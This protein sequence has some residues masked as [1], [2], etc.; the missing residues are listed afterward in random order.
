MRRRWRSNVRSK[1][2]RAVTRCEMVCMIGFCITPRVL[3]GFRLVEDAKA[4]ESVARAVAT[5]GRSLMIE[6]VTWEL[7]E[8][9]EGEDGLLKPERCVGLDLCRLMAVAKS[10]EKAGYCG[11]DDGSGYDLLSNGG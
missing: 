10:T 3:S 1:D 5:T 2:E 8:V 9:E 4:G 11:G 7:Y 6:R